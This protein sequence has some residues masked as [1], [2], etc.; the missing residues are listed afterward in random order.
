MPDIVKSI[1]VGLGVE[2]AIYV[3]GSPM[4]AI[5]RGDEGWEILF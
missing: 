3:T 1:L 4:Y 5:W 2:V